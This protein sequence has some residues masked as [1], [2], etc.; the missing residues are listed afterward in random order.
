MSDAQVPRGFLQVPHALLR[1][2]MDPIFLRVYLV[3]ASFADGKVGACTAARET[4]AEASGCSANSVKRA[5]AVLKNAGWIEVEERPGWSSVIRPTQ[6]KQLD[7]SAR[8]GRYPGL[9]GPTPGLTG[10]TPGPHRPTKKTEIRR[11]NEE[12]DLKT[13]ASVRRRMSD[14]QLTMLVDLVL[15]Q[16]LDEDDPE[17]YVRGLVSSYTE[18]DDLIQ[19]YWVSIEHAGRS[20]VAYTARRTPS[21]YERLSAKGRAFVDRE[22][23]SA[24]GVSVG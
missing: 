11:L 7:L 12:D 10:P 2:G 9:T 13:N 5:V 6:P 15:L 18:A 21:I 4:I 19:E 3:I 14:A 17:G 20:E 23:A 24:G 16:D 22:D 8:E 1:S